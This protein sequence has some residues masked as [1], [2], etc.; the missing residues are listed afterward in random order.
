MPQE[1]QLQSWEREG[2]EEKYVKKYDKENIQI[3]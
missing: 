3:K 1:A 2:N